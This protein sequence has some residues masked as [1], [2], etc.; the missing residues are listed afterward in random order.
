MNMGELRRM[1][2]ASAREVL[3]SRKFQEYIS[4]MKR[5][6]YLGLKVSEIVKLIEG[7]HSFRSRLNKLRIDLNSIYESL[8]L[9]HSLSLPL[10]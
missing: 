6:Y 9:E 7:Q 10:I 5:Y 3:R 2:D 4:G 8:N 1:S